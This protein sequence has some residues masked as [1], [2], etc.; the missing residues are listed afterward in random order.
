MQKH[1]L[2][3]TVSQK[4]VPFYINSLILTFLGINVAKKV[5]NQNCTLFSH[6]T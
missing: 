5:G 2:N 1:E 6:H 4:N 3:Y